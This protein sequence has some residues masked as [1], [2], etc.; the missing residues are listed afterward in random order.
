M[1]ELQGRVAVITGGASGMGLAFAHRFAAAG[2][3][4]VLGDI[5]VPALDAAVEG[6][7]GEDVEVLG[8]RCDVSNAASV[9][10]LAVAAR[11]SFGA[12]HVVCLNAGV[13]TSGP[14][15]EQTL[16][17]WQWILGVNLMGIVHGLDAFLPGLV[18]Q[19]EG[20]VVITASVAG[21]TAYPGLGPYSASKHAAAAIAETLHNELSTS[22][23]RVGATAL[24]PGF[25][26][27]G[28]FESDRN[29]PEHLTDALAEPES[30]ED[31]EHRTAFLE[32][33]ANEARKPAEVADLV[34]DAILAGTFWVF[35]DEQHLLNISNRHAEIAERRNPAEGRTI[36]EEAL[37]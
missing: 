34:H 8:V 11:E 25:V 28:I 5:E 37:D 4:V 6:L 30:D 19:D 20:H 2:M 3:K 14:L 15:H 13:A 21:H 1:D 7:R 16:S 24:C 9:R 32:M 33:I 36:T 18:A 23:S 26:D 12:V 22:G 31:R 29:R 10:D 35:T 17:D 27:T